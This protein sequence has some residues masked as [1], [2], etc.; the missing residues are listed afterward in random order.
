MSMQPFVNLYFNPKGQCDRKTYWLFFAIPFAIMGLLFGILEYNLGS[1][2]II[3]YLIAL[4]PIAW[5]A[6]VFQIKRLKDIGH[7]GWFSI[8]SFMPIIG[9]FISVII[10][11]IPTKE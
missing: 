9:F 3:V 5:S 2:N 6:L 11:V 1:F 4:P 7:S 10:G 8:L